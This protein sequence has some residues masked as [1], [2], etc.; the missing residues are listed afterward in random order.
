MEEEE[1]EVDK[2]RKRA[3]EVER[4]VRTLSPHASQT[5]VRRRL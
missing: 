1:E 3:G 5:R 4:G 2:N